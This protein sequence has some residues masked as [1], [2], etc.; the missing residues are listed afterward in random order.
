MQKLKNQ[1]VWYKTMRLVVFVFFV[2]SVFA[3][4]NRI[5]HKQIAEINDIILE[6]Q[7]QWNAGNIEGFMQAYWQHDSLRFI[8]KSGIQYGWQTV[9]DRYDK[10]YPNTERMG[11]LQFEILHQDL[12]S[13]NNIQTTGTWTL[14]RTNDT[15][16][17][18]FVLL[19]HKKPEGWK[20]ISDATL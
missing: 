13:A 20:I 16:G 19:W 6:Q 8:S 12:V 4:Q 15:L 3:C 5:E 1:E 9:K 17:G 14:F 2:F 10:A 18:Y 7:Q 11:K